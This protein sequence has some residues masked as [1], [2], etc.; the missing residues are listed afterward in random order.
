MNLTGA[1]FYALCSDALMSSISERIEH[2]KER[3]EKYENQQ[4]EEENTIVVEHY[5]FQLALKNLVPSVSEQEL[6]RYKLIQK[7]FQQEN[8]RC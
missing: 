1:D 8:K 7:Q 3:P 2:L 5:H 4:R 6:E